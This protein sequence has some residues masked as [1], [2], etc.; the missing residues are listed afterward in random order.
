MKKTL[1]VVFGL[2]S[3]V[4]LALDRAPDTEIAPTTV[5]LISIDTLRA[6]GIGNS[7]RSTP[8]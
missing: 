6:E 8:G 2:C 4:A 1:A 7:F 5:V 3:A